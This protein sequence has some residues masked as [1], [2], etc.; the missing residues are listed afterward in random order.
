RR[1]DHFRAQR[2]A[3]R[4]PADVA[5]Y[6]P[7]AELAPRRINGNHGMRALVRVHPERHHVFVTSM[8]VVDTRAGRQTP[9]SWG[10]A[11][12]LSSHADRSNVSD[13]WHF[14]PEATHPGGQ[15]MSEPGCRTRAE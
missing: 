4:C 14:I 3:S 8:W 1:A 2:S 5:I 12:L 6:R 9:L 7:L 13:S 11:A 15:P 10:E